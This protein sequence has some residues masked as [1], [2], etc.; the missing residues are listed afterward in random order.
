MD[1]DM[2]NMGLSDGEALD[3]GGAEAEINFYPY[4]EK[5]D[6][7]AHFAQKDE[8]T[9][10]A[11]GAAQDNDNTAGGGLRE[12]AD[13]D[14]Y[15]GKDTKYGKFKNPTELLKAYG[16]LEKEFTRRSQRLK[17]LEEGVAPF[18]SEKEWKGAVDK[19][20]EQT[21]SARAFAKD[22]ANEIIAHPELKRSRDCFNIALTHV[23]I[24]K[25]RTPEQL[26]SD[27]QFL[28]EYVFNSPVV[29]DT[30]IAEYLSSLRNGQPPHTMANGGMQI[31]A[32]AKKPG[33]I[34]EA[35]LMFLKNNK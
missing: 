5:P 19:F 35:G 7:G 32:P 31:V 12:R 16:Q 15:N 2:L 23:L 1:D 33:S 6:T 24:D 8:Q 25:F 4:A 18:K 34:E 9:D 13:V 27:G 28:K 21:P 17:E 30:V 3:A 26:M 29:R 22:I 11:E 14:K 20:F 10:A